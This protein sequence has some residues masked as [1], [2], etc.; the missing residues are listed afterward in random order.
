MKILAKLRE[1]IDFAEDL[2]AD[3]FWPM[4][5]YQKLLTIF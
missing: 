4:A 2:V 5:S 1:Q 3:E